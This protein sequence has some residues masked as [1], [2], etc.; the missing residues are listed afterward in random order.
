MNTWHGFPGRMR[1]RQRDLDPERCALTHAS[2][3]DLNRSAMQLGQLPG[4]GQSESESASLARQSP[5]RLAETLEYV[6]KNSGAIPIPV[7]LTVS[8]M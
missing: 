5:L 8:S 6:G 2:A 1:D 3:R 7:S 4:D